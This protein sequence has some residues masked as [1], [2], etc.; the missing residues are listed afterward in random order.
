MKILIVD[1]NESIT[2][3][4]VKYLKLK[5][6][7]CTAVNNARNALALILEQKFDVIFLDLAMPEFSGF[8]IIDSLEKNDKLKENKIIIFSASNVSQEIID[9]LLR[10]GVHSTI[11]K[12]APMTHLLQ[13]IGV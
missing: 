1:D 8:D 6:L 9:G 3:M 4:M 12:P 5:K 7:D 10:R 11:S 2:Q 13:A